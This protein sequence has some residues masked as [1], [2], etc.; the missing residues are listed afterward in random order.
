MTVFAPETDDRAANQL[1]A[2]MS[3]RQH[4]APK[5][6]IAPGPSEDALALLFQ[7]AASAPDHG[8]IQPWRFVIV[9]AAKRAAL[10]AAFVQALL[11]RDPGADADQMAAAQEKALRAPCLVFAVLSNAPCHPPVPQSERLLSL[12]C[13]IQN[14]LLMA[15]ALSIGSGIS[16]GKA[17]NDPAIRQLFALQ[18]VED[19]I[20][21]LSFGTILAR[22]PARARRDYTAFVTTL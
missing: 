19:G 2:C 3:A 22:K 20:C 7:A 21:F 5:R 11:R 13:A 17:M 12:G 15:Q 1:L 8:R 6:L 9:P 4:V 16:S 14:M 18:D 10:G